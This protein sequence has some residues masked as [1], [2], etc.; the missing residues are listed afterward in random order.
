MT[1]LIALDDSPRA[2]HVFAAGTELARLTG[3][4]VVLVRVLTEPT[5]IPPAAHTQPSHLDDEVEQAVRAEF[6]RLMDSSPGVRF[7]APIVVAGDPWRRI[8][9]VADRIGADLIVMGNHRPHGVERVLGTVASRV[10]S[11]ADRSVLLVR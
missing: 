10:V 8:L 2:P 11:H 3:A 5:D 9:E 1:A 7:G 6:G 4:E